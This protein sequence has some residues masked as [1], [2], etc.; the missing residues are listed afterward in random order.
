MHFGL[1][2][3]TV[4]WMLTCTFFNLL[5]LTAVCKP[6]CPSG[7]LKLHCT[8]LFITYVTSVSVHVLLTDCFYFSCLLIYSNGILKNVIE[9]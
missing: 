2:M 9:Y 7:T 8:L 5:L 4:M 1:T 6:Y 3:M